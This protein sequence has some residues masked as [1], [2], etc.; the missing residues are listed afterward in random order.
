METRPPA[1]RKSSIIS[2][3]AAAA[4]ILLSEKRAAPTPAG[5]QDGTPERLTTCTRPPN[6]CRTA[7][8]PEAEEGRTASPARPAEPASGSRPPEAPAPAPAK[9]ARIRERA[10]TRPACLIEQRTPPPCWTA[11]ARTTSGNA[12]IRPPPRSGRSRPPATD[13]FFNIAEMRNQRK[14]SPLDYPP[15]VILSVILP[16]FLL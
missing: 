5:Q 4:V 3:P 14:P 8:Q 1:S 9:K 2:R 16:A 6:R 12:G 10:K 13:D 11:P 15:A 7:S